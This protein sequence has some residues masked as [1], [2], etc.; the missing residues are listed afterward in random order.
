MGQLFPP[1][2][3]LWCYLGCKDH[4]I[5][6]GSTTGSARLN[7]EQMSCFSQF[8]PLLREIDRVCRAC[9]TFDT[10]GGNVFRCKDHQVREVVC[11]RD[12]QL[13]PE[14]GVVEN[15]QHRAGTQRR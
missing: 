5:L 12:V 14:L 3:D 15:A 10:D 2:G 13:K 1:L 4:A 8:A 9:L 6:Y 11:G 7:L